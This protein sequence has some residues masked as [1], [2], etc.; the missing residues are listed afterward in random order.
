MIPTAQKT[1][2]LNLALL[3]ERFLAN[4][5]ALD[6]RYP[7]LATTLRS[8]VPR[9]TY[10]ISTDRDCVVLGIGQAGSV[11]A[12]PTILSPASAKATVESMFPDKNCKVAL[13]AGEDLGWL[14][15]I[16][17]QM[18]VTVPSAPG[19]R[20]PLFFL[21]KD[22]ERLWVILHIQDWKTLL[23]DP[24]VRLFAGDD[25]V[26]QFRQSLLDEPRC[27]W[28][29]LA[30]T[31]LPDTWPDGV[32]FDL[33][34]IE[35]CAA[36]RVELL[37][38]N[39]Q[40]EMLSTSASP[41]AIAQRTKAGQS[42]RVLGITSR[43]TSFIQH[44]MR[45]W[46]DAF[47]RLGHV[48][49]LEIEPA[50]HL[51]ANNLSLGAACAEFQP[52]LIV[53]IDHYRA[54]LSGIPANVPMVM[55]VQDAMPALFTAAAGAAQGPLDFAMGIAP[56]KMVHEF[57]YPQ[58]RYM[59]ALI[60]VN[61]VR[62]QPHPNDPLESGR[63]SCDVSFVSHASTTPQK[64]LQKALQQHNSPQ[65]ARLINEVFDRLKDIYDSNGMVTEPI[66]IQRLIES[67][68]QRTQTRITSDHLPTL[69][70]LFTAQINNAFFR[71]QPLQWLADAGVNLHLYGNG[72]EQHPTLSRFA[73]GPADNQTRLASIYRSS[74]INLHASPYG[75]VHQRVLEVLACGGLPMF[76]ACPGDVL[77]RHF[78]PIWEF[79]QSRQITTDAELKRQA[80][81]EIQNVLE[82]IKQSLQ[83]S[84]FEEPWSF[85]EAMRFSQTEGNIR[86]AG[87]IWGKDYDAAAF[88][89]AE[90]LTQKVA[91]F[92]R[93]DN[94]RERLIKSMQKPVIERF[95]YLAMT[96]KLL[97]FVA[98]NLL[99]NTRAR[100]S[101]A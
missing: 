74:K 39:K 1:S 43:Y 32:T 76:R 49:R 97:D 98:E 65:T 61:D 101:A 87:T 95:T 78:K 99:R 12:L 79:C 18:P 14:W 15:N 84:P 94:A 2:W 31:I 13:V 37:R 50:D 22:L 56:L 71:H 52:D 23:A 66:V 19:H 25:C 40:L 64:H 67:A 86:C 69:M 9:Q 68:A 3:N 26:Q 58:E 48:T 88:G 10:F 62:F 5:S 38:L 34:F 11:Q 91:R 7:S 44:S 33:I 55:W 57:G 21:M 96:R 75:A 82:K 6:T 41:L 63:F 77:D 54:T 45:D 90:E 16:L 83:R 100:S 24:R 70:H 4:V 42:L 72:W 20:P 53:C 46:L 89:S 85:M 30:V 60:G 8:L 47:T 92:L 36:Q 29:Q 17:Y 59:P 80:T 81:P 51:V 27:P 35:S 93:D 28:P 73:R